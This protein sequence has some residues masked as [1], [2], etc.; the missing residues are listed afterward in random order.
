MRFRPLALLWV[1]LL[2]ASVAAQAEDDE[3]PV[4]RGKV[5][6][7]GAN[8]RVFAVGAAPLSL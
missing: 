3:P 2:P 1:A 8:G 7:F 5:E 6:T 4:E